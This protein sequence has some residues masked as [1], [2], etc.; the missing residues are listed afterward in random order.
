MHDAN[1]VQCWSALVE[2]KI[3]LATAD[4]VGVRASE[5]LKD[6]ESHLLAHRDCV[7]PIEQGLKIARDCGYGL[8]HIDL[9]L[10]RARLHLL[11]GD[12]EAALEDVEVALDTGI[13]PNEETGQ[14]ELLAANHEECGYAWAIPPGLQLRAEAL[15]L[16]AAQQLR[17][18]SFDVGWV[19]TQPTEYATIA[20]LIEKAKQL[21][22]EAMDR[23]HE[24]R[25]PEPTE[26]NNFKLDGK[27]Y[28]YR[29]EETQRV[30]SDLEL[31]LLTSFPLQPE[32]ATTESGSGESLPPASDRHK[33]FI[34]YSHVDKPWL[35]RLLKHLKP[36]QA[37]IEIT[38][39]ADDQIEPG[40]QWLTEIQKA[41]ATSKA[42]VLLVS[43]DFLASEFIMQHELPLIVE[44]AERGELKILWIPL[45]PSAYKKTGIADYQAL[46]KP[47]IT[48]SELPEPQQ[49]GAWLE[50]CERIQEAVGS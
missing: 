9:L 27:E 36:F 39:W 26:D 6:D 29:A 17:Q 22:H 2:A 35:Q 40:Q 31:G 32:K 11:R 1:E 20:P 25:D 10:E 47:A 33:I 14:V 18:A 30:I 3:E 13:P 8:Y 50:I 19:S 4:K 44:A 28:N 34:S 48:L 49:D 45:K 46:R 43:P 42:A 5:G 7:D 16:Q 15:L 23:W 21:L 24:L 37:E 38:P 41:I 12:A